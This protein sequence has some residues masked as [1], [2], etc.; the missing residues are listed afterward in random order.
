MNK[1]LFIPILS[2][3]LF[4]TAC[5]KIDA[6]YGVA[7]DSPTPSDTE[8]VMRKVLIED[9]TG[10]T[11]GNCPR[12]AES[13]TQIHELYG[14]KIVAMAIH[15]GFFAE[16]AGSHYPNDYRTPEGNE[17]DTYFGNAAAG[18]PNGLVNRK[19]FDGQTI[20]QHTAWSSKATE[21][22]AL[23]IEAFMWI[24]PTYTAANRSLSVSIKTRFYQ[25]IEEGVSL[26][27]YVTEDSIISSQKDYNL[28]DPSLI[29]NYTHR[30]MLRGSINGAWGT[31]IGAA[32]TFATGEEF[33]NTGTITIPESWNS[34]HLSVVAVLYRTATKEVIQAEDQ[35]IY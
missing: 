17:L 1:L 33:T 13:L 15:A 6:P 24:T 31:S 29:D 28:P 22:V 18:L 5:D 30:H 20:V 3:L 32:T 26:A 21:L 14:E 34:D 8:V 12:A 2:S 4:F 23:P 25:N 27:M 35:K 7:T 11:C 9:F 19:A 16:P 10:Q